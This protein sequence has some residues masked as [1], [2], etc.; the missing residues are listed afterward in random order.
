MGNNVYKITVV[1]N[2]NNGSHTG[3]EMGTAYVEMPAGTSLKEAQKIGNKMI[4]STNK[5]NKL[6]IDPA[7]RAL[8]DSLPR[9]ASPM[10]LFEHLTEEEQNAFFE[11]RGIE[12]VG[13]PSADCNPL[14]GGILGSGPAPADPAPRLRLTRL[15][16]RRRPT[17]LRPR[18]RLT[19]LRLTRLRPRRRLTRLRPRRRPACRRRRRRRMTLPLQ[20]RRVPT[21]AATVRRR[22]CRYLRKTPAPADGRPRPSGRE[23]PQSGDVGQCRSPVCGSCRLR[24]IGREKRLPPCRPASLRHCGLIEVAE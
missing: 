3:H 9:G 6:T 22:R 16:P 11:G 2:N 5:N 13:R 4:P 18:L 17:R 24:T 21:P 12:T 15:R 14:E 8:F 23:D 20:T 19:R 1:S 10:I 7:A